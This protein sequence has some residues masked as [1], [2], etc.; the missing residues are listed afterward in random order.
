MLAAVSALQRDDG[1]L[2]HAQRLAT[3][4]WEKHWKADNPHWKVGDN[5]LMVI[6]QI[7]NAVAGLVRQSQ[8]ADERREVR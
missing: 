1:A 5:L 3:I 6:D 8:V 4:L 2:R 7:D